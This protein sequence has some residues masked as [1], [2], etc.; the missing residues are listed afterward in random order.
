MQ[1]LGLV[2]GIAFF[3]FGLAQFYLGA[4]GLDLVIGHWWAGAAVLAAIFFRFTLPLSIGC[5]IYATKVW[6]W[7]WWGGVLFAAPGLAF[8]VPGALAALLGAVFRRKPGRQDT[9]ARAAPVRYEAIEAADLLDD[10]A[11]LADPPAPPNG[12][13]R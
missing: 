7:P 6:G 3:A 2:G 5:F 9:A 11:G 13:G 8:M 10:G 1:V 4:V 12:G